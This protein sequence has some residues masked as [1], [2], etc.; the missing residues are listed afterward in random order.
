VKVSQEDY[1][2]KVEKELRKMRQTSQIKGFRPGNAPM[3][4]IKKM[5]WHPVLLEE[6]NKL[7]SESI[8]NY[9]KENAEQLLG[10]V[11]PS[12]KSQPVNIN[13]Q[14]DFEFVYEAGFYP[15]FTYQIDENTE[16]TYYNIIPDDSE[17]DNELDFIRNAQYTAENVEEIEDNCFVNV[18]VNL[19]KDGENKIHNADFVMS[20]I[21]DEDKA[22][23]LG[24]KK[25]DSIN[26]EIRKVFTNEIDL[27]GMLGLNKEELALQPQTLSFTIIKI[28]KKKPF[29]YDQQFF[30]LIAGEDKIHSREELR[31]YIRG[32]V[33]EGNEQVSLEKLY[34]DSVEILKEKANVSLPEDFIR[35][36]IS[37]VQKK[38]SGLT[39][40]KFESAV[41]YFIETT[42]LEYITDSLL[43]QA[44]IELTAGMVTDE[45]KA[46][47]L[48]K[49][50]GYQLQSK[51]L[52][53]LVNYYL[54]NE[55]YVHSVLNRLKR[56]RIAKLL[57]EN[58]KL[59]V[60]NISHTEF[61]KLLQS[62]NAEADNVLE[63]IPKTEEMATDET[64]TPEPVTEN[65]ETEMTENQENSK[66]EQA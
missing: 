45:M 39:E 42:K 38:D 5:Y 59:H 51:E 61:K 36:Y 29:N 41:Q 44:G 34:T 58:A 47:I 27:M 4:L 48:E 23:F 60:I 11:I 3:S 10:G 2:A 6:I 8:E 1:A 37:S 66:E 21:P 28:L 65:Q 64:A 43:E 50:N 12:E 30:D 20:V 13:T 17:V 63:Y 9:E 19:I 14:T 32:I 40:E 46:I 16:L 26:V 22:L 24:A 25:G 33:H 49:Y 62:E 57:K 55:E 52:N 53:D 35:R 15:E 31:E 56:K 7:I 18:D 54:A